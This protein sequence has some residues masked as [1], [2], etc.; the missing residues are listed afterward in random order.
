MS[1]V[2][3]DRAECLRLLATVSIGRFVFTTGALPAVLP[4]VFTIDQGTVLAGVASPTGLS[5][6]D[7]AVAAFQADHVDPATYTGWSVTAIGE[8]QLLGADELATRGRMLPGSAR[9]ADTH[10]FTIDP[11]LLTGHRF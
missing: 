8:V 4:V 3:L 5:R 1:L 11:T 7:R 2:E 10:I 9:L 6:Q